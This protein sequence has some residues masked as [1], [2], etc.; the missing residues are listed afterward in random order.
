ML[1]DLAPYSLNNKSFFVKNIEMENLTY[2]LGKPLIVTDF[3]LSTDLI[4]SY[5]KYPESVVSGLT[6]IGGILALVRIV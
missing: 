3:Y 5:Y 4:D 2:S 6:K 1:R